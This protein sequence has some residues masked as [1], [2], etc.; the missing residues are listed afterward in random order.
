MFSSQ[1]STR[2]ILWEQGAGPEKICLTQAVFMAWIAYVHL[3]DLL[4]R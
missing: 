3:F 4:P 1:Y 2:E